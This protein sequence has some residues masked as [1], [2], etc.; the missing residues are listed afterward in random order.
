MSLRFGTDGVRGLAGAEL[1]P[2]L[3]LTLG[4]AAARVL[5][6]D[7]F[8]VGRDT[9]ASGPMLQAALSA[10]LAA[11]GADVVDL[12]VIPTPGVAAVAAGRAAAAAVISASHNPHHDNGVKLLAPGGTK[13]TDE[14]EQRVEA[15]MSDLGAARR[16]QAAPPARIGSLVADHDA[17]GWYCEH[18]VESLEGRTL[19]G[20]R[21]VLDCANGAASATAERI[22]SRAGADVVDVLANRPD[23][24]NINAGSGSTDP[25]GLAGAVRAA[26]ADAGLAFDG[27]ADRVIAV[28]EHGD[29]VDG[30]RLLALFAVD[31]KD[32]DRLAGDTLVATVMSNLGLE[33]AMAAA[34]I[35]VHRTPVGDRNVLEALDANRWSLGGEQSGHIIFRDVATTGDGVLSGLMLLDLVS[36]SGRKLSELAREAMVS[37][38][39]VQLNVDVPPG[40]GAVSSPRVAEA[41]RVVEAELGSGGRVVLRPSGTEPLVRV[42]VEADTEDAAQA[43]ARRLVEAVRDAAAQ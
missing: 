29:I 20:L 21:V 31:L 22:V 3:V 2:E 39:Q 35:R 10:G 28:D 23:G 9:R 15:E 30:D 1:S 42:M 43:A 13:L 40:S 7:T 36:R 24:V 27:D 16:D 26:G 19:D 17:L 18:V 12:G 32:R 6:S 14:Q 34:G 41:V 33:K 38:P 37:L 11:E 4:R 5:G 8:V 25:A